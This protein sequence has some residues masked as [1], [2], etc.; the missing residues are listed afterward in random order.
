MGCS[1]I[2]KT[3]GHNNDTAAFIRIYESDY[4]LHGMPTLIVLQGD[5]FLMTIQATIVQENVIGIWDTRGDTLLF[6]PK[7]HTGIRQKKFY[8][9]DTTGFGERLKRQRVFI[10]KEKQLLEIG[11]MGLK[12]SSLHRFDSPNVYNYIPYK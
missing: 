8:V 5:P 2:I 12:D 3:N 4:C 1:A 10:V 6:T 7:V 9:K 11:Y